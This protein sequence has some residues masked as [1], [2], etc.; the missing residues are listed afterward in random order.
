MGGHVHV[1][2]PCPLCRGP[3][4]SRA[5][6]CDACAAAHRVVLYACESCKALTPPLDLSLV[7]GREL[8]PLCALGVDR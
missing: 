3:R 2:R 6:L 7:D 8:C 4:S 5:P 1:L